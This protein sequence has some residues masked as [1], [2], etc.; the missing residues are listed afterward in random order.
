MK[1]RNLLVGLVLALMVMCAGS[2]TTA[3][4]A[5]P[6]CATVC[7][8]NYIAC[9]NSCAGDPTCLAECEADFDCCRIIC[10]GQDCFAKT[11]KK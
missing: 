9:K 10:H 5:R 7:F 6:S 11:S 1:I 2:L 8:N 3:S 4:P